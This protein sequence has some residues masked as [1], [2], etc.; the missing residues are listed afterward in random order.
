MFKKIKKGYLTSNI[1]L[2]SGG[3]G[4][5]CVYTHLIED[6]ED[7]YAKVFPKFPSYIFDK[8]RQVLS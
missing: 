4:R 5:V 2:E 7:Y 8:I 6:L 3:S 1:E